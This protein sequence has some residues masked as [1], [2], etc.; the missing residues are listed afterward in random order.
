MV[1]MTSEN[2]TYVADEAM[3]FIDAVFTRIGGE[4][5]RRRK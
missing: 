4:E 1:S 2:K 5:C 3:T